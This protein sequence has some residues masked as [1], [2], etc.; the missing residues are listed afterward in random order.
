MARFTRLALS[1]QLGWP[2]AGFCQPTCRLKSVCWVAAADESLLI[3]V[4][5]CRLAA[6]EQNCPEPARTLG[7]SKYEIHPGRWRA[8]AMLLNHSS[9]VLL[10][11]SSM[12]LYHSSSVLLYHSSV[13]LY[14]SSMLLYH[15]SMGKFLPSRVSRLFFPRSVL[16]ELRSGF[17]WKSVYPLLC[18]ARKRTHTLS[19]EIPICLFFFN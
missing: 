6:L 9:S 1:R 11:H 2:S 7:I 10:Y 8:G 12:L 19:D 17:V 3:V 14:H 5:S 16:R 15:S 4:K 18:I 13:L